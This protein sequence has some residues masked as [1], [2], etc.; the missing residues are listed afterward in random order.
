MASNVVDVE[1]EGLTTPPDHAQYSPSVSHDEEDRPNDTEITVGGEERE[2]I[3]DREGGE[4]EEKEDEEWEEFTEEGEVDNEHE[5][6]ERGDN[7]PETG[8]WSQSSTGTD[9]LRNKEN[10]A[11]GLLLSQNT[12]LGNN[13][14]KKMAKNETNESSQNEGW[15]KQKLSEDD[16]LRLQEQASWSKEP[17]FFADMMPVVTKTS[18]PLESG[19]EMGENIGK[20]SLQYQPLEIE[21]VGALFRI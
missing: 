9:I 18:D 21:E 19:P 16:Q 7:K 5:W 12:K 14:G 4:E 10:G 6:K 15:D 17:D 13:G 2:G 1:S 11:K 20:S 8:S 3:G